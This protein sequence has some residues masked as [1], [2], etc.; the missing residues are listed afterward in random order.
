M[1][2]LASD[3]I[4]NILDEA[5]YSTVSNANIAVPGSPGNKAYRALLSGINALY[6]V[7]I[8]WFWNLPEQSVAITSGQT[9]TLDTRTMVNLIQEV[10][11]AADNGQRVPL[12]G[13]DV[14]KLYSDVYS[15]FD[16]I[17]NLTGP[18]THWFIDGGVFKIFPAVDKS[19]TLYLRYPRLPQKFNASVAG[20]TYLEIGDELSELLMGFGLWRFQR[21]IKDPEWKDNRLLYED[22]TAEG[23]MINELIA[24]NKIIERW[25]GARI[26]FSPSYLPYTNHS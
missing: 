7:A 14:H 25:N 12:A 9:P 1:A 2:I 23:S 10:Y 16:N 8:E 15:R 13:I 4:N 19:Y 18:P 3:I 24:N 20:T 26:N 6:N 17:T 11:Y 21:K 22:Q 5:G